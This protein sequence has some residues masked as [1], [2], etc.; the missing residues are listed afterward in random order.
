MQ[1]AA[2]GVE[3]VADVPIYFADAIARRSPPLLETRDGQAP[4][5]W[6][7]ATRAATLGGAE[8]DKVNVKQGS[9]SAALTAAIDKKLP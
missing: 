8:G 6:L 5:A 3:R 9:G 2:G 4:K 7:S 1:A